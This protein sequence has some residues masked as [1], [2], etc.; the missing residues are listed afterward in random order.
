MKQNT[1][2]KIKNIEFNFSLS[3]TSHNF[4]FTA[5]TCEAINIYAC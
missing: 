1:N 4:K 2:E 5:E 3:E